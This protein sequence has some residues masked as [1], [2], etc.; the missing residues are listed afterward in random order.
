M[1][2]LSQRSR[3]FR[4][5][6]MFEILSAAQELE[7]NG[8]SVIH[9]EIGDTKGFV[10]PHIVRELRAVT[11]N[12]QLGYVASG[13]TPALRQAFARQYSA[14]KG[15]AFTERNVV[16]APANALISQYL[17]VTCDPGDAVLIPDPGFPTYFLGAE[18][19]G[20]RVITYPLDPADGWNPDPDGIEELVRQNPGIR[21]ILVNSPSNPLGTVMSPDRLEALLDLADRHGLHCLFDETYKNLVFDGD[22]PAPRHR[23]G[24]TYLYSLS[25][26]AAAP[27]LRVGCAVSEDTELIGKLVDYS[28]LFFSCGPGLMQEAALA[29]VSRDDSTEFA[30]GIRE[31]IATRV[32]TADKILAET[33]GLSYVRPSAAFYLFLDISSTGLTSRDFAYRLL[34]EQQVC[35]CPGDSFGQQGAGCVRVTLAGDPAELE[36]GLRR[37]AAFVR[38]ARTEA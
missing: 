26:D 22:T 38:S 10:N 14:E 12:P 23:P 33:E 32:E 13:G 1:H 37:L 7:Q 5:Q 17:G 2:A 16:V 29:Y 9:L 28:S 3:V 21:C 6:P 31:E 30:R 35:V 24:V 36:E 11:E 19:N 27:G 8:Q 18:F 20:L 25:K 15:V 4:P 34:R